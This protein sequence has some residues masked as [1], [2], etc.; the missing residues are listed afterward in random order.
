MLAYFKEQERL[1]APIPKSLGDLSDLPDELVKELSAKRVD[2][3]EEQILVVI[4]ACGGEA[5]LDQVLVGLYRKYK[6]VQTRRYTQN[7]LYRMSQKELIYPLPGQRAA[8][9]LEPQ[10][11]EKKPPSTFDQDLDDEIPF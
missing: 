3:L 4:R 7:K 11:E 8:Y 10:A 9:S 2:D 5:N 1:A 6:V